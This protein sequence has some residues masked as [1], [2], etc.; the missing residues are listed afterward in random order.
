[1]LGFGARAASK[2]L[3][4][5]GTRAV[6]TIGPRQLARIGPRQ[7]AR[8]GPRQVATVGSR[9]VATIGPRQV[10]RIGPRALATIGPRALVPVA[11]RGL[12]RAATTASKATAKRARKTGFRGVD[13]MG[14][15]KKALAGYTA[16]KVGKSLAKT[17]A[18]VGATLGVDYAL[19]RSEGGKPL[20]MADLRKIARDSGLGII[21]RGMQGKADA[22][23]VQDELLRATRTQLRKKSGH[24]R[25]PLTERLRALRDYLEE[26]RRRRRQKLGRR[27]KHL[28]P[29]RVFGTGLIGGGGGGKKKKKTSKK[30]KKTKAKKKK[31]KPRKKKKAVKKKKKKKKKKGKKKKGTS[32]AT[33]FSFSAARGG[34]K[35][36][37]K[38][39][40]MNLGASRARYEKMRDVF[41]I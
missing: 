37:L 7:L 35:K 11:R 18:L 41:D 23:A 40:N 27:P 1:V 25:G 9:Q 6:A 19:H 13:M 38:K 39:V 17:G 5:L 36:G 21:R 15:A 4:P 3:V 20:T 8:I 2:A 32:A 33:Y 30:K 31:K 10:A 22:A 24:D 14:P 26:Q 12:K 34:R 16:L 28:K 29:A